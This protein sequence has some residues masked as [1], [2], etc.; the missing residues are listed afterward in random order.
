MKTLKTAFCLLMVVTA[1]TTG[2]KKNDENEPGSGKNNYTYL[3]ETK[4]ITEARSIIATV[5]GIN[6]LSVTLKGEGTSKWVQLH[7]YK[8]GTTVPTGA[9][10]YKT[11]LDGSYNPAANFSG[12]NV[13]LDIASAHEIN[14]GT[15]N[16]NKNGDNYTFVL[17]A[18]TSRGSVKATYTG[19]VT[20]Q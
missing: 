3:D 7:F 17:D 2:C 4:K 19:K 6:T 1:L 18:K 12:G 9:F 16:V 13:N 8:S 10:T 5:L 20:A 15:L 14:G 11:N